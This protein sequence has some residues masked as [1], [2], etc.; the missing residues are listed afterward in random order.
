MVG[1]SQQNKAVLID[2]SR[3]WVRWMWEAMVISHTS[4]IEV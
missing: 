3:D 4:M 1:G 2:A